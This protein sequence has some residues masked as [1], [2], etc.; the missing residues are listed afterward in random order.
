M[1]LSRDRVSAGAASA[2]REQ[3]AACAVR[4]ETG[5]T[6]V[7]RACFRLALALMFPGAPP[8]RAGG[9]PGSPAECPAGLAGRGPGARSQGVAGVSGARLAGTGLL[10]DD[11]FL[12]AHCDRTGKPLLQ[13]RATGLGLAGA[14]L[15]ELTLLGK[16]RV[17][18]GRDHGD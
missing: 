15:A 14:L 12:M 2:G 5:P 18:S 17:S 13:P 7:F 1:F 4:Y 10:A 6:A 16:I 11:L 9:A 8:A 3:H